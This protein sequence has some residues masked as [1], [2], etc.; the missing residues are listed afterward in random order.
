MI[1]LSLKRRVV[2]MHP[3]KEYDIFIVYAKADYEW[4]NGY[5]I[6]ALKNAGFKINSPEQF[7]FGLPEIN[8]FERGITTSKRILIIVSHAYTN[9]SLNQFVASM[10]QAY[11]LESGTWPVIPI[12]RDL[13]KIPP[14][15]DMLVKLDA[16]DSS[17]RTLAIQ[18][19]SEQLKRPIPT[20]FVLPPC[21]YPGLLTFNEQTSHNFFGRESEIEI[22]KTRL[23]LVSFYMIIGSSGCGKSSLVKAGILPAIRSGQIFRQSN[24][25][26]KELRFG[27]NPS[28][29]SLDFIIKSIPVITTNQQHLLLFIDQFEEIFY[30]DQSEQ[31]IIIDQLINISEQLKPYFHCIMTMRSD[32]YTDLIESNLW[33]VVENNKFELGQL[34]ARGLREA[35]IKP[36]ERS[37]VY[38][39][40]AL[41]E[42]L[43]TEAKTGKSVLPFLQETLKSLWEKIERRYLSIESYEALVLPYQELYGEGISGFEI[44]LSRIADQSLAHLSEKQKHLVQRILLQLINFNDERAHT[45]RLQTL[46]DLKIEQDKPRDFQIALDTLIEHRLV[47]I[48]S[49][50]RKTT[51]VEISHDALISGWKTLKDWIKINITREKTRR[52]ITNKAEIWKNRESSDD[53]LLT[54]GEY[55]SLIQ[56]IESEKLEKDLK[57]DCLAFIKANYKNINPKLSKIGIAVFIIIALLT[58][59]NSYSILDIMIV[60]SPRIYRPLILIFAFIFLLLSLIY[61]TIS[62]F[63]HKYLIQKT[64]WF[65]FRK[66]KSIWLISFLIISSF[67]LSFTFYEKRNESLCLQSGFNLGWL[68]ASSIGISNSN[69]STLQVDIFT[70]NLSKFYIENVVIQDYGESELDKC[71]QYLTHSFEVETKSTNELYSARLIEKSFNNYIQ[72][73]FPEAKKPTV[74]R[75]ECGA[76]YKLSNQLY[77]LKYFKGRESFILDDLIDLPNTLDCNHISAIT[78]T[79][80]YL[81]K[82]HYDKAHTSFVENYQK[83]SHDYLSLA[84]ALLTGIDLNKSININLEKIKNTPDLPDYIYYLIGELYLERKDYTQAEIYYKKSLALPYPWPELKLYLI[85]NIAPSLF[86]KTD[87]SIEDFKAKTERKL[88]NLK[89]GTAMSAYII[90]NRYDIEKMASELI[91]SFVDQSKLNT[92]KDICNQF[93]NYLSDKRNQFINGGAFLVSKNLFKDCLK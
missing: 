10:S 14:R 30:A 87:E 16:S 7:T 70:R 84:G 52:T 8:E 66:I 26:I 79:N 31:R 27:N 93:N 78:E 23:H 75:T 92:T 22:I 3:E 32:F 62:I 29:E 6:D 42:R 53:W 11:G 33:T 17:K 4:V 48:N 81:H 91:Y 41:V 88:E 34:T 90:D 1:I 83:N 43:V 9:D 46:D 60:N 72:A 35:I 18:R 13:I 25:L 12:L 77:S 74:H 68:S 69:L 2:F 63:N 80:Y 67:I 5:L 86:I 28:I 49:H 20:S 54:Q 65:F 56:V 82:F 38:I 15:L 21:P 44:T 47:V 45:R 55:K 73:K 57:N 19:L 39:E 36:A 76:L 64:S 51:H 24:C 71:S 37:G 85:Y 89:R 59:L 58:L 40:T 50:D 61:I